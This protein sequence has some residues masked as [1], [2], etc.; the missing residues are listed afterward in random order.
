MSCIHMVYP[1]VVVL[2]LMQFAPV[3][4]QGKSDA[5]KDWQDAEKETDRLD[6]RWRLAD[7]EAD[8]AKI[9]DKENS[10]LHIIAVAKSAPNV[11]VSG[12]ANYEA[13]F[14]KLPATAQLN[15][16][17]IALIDRKSTRLNSSHIQKSRMPSSA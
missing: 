12:A 10:A 11:N 4:G 16:Q 5:P 17:Q 14:E 3:L 15:A 8:R 9:P 7:I 13:L 6:P 2:A 1:L